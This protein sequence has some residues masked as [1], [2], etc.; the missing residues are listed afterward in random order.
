MCHWLFN[1]SGLNS[2]PSG[3]DSDAQLTELIA[4]LFVFAQ[5]E[6]EESEKRKIQNAHDSYQTQKAEKREGKREGEGKRERKR[7]KEEKKIR[8]SLT[9]TTTE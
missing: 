6:G 9:T 8:N 5:T 1:L 3:S 2:S 7:E 4:L